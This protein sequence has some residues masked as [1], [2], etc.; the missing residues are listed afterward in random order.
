MVSQHPRGG[1]SPQSARVRFCDTAGRTR[2]YSRRRR[3]IR[4]WVLRLAVL[5]RADFPLLMHKK[6]TL[7]NTAIR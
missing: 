2:R 3:M 6:L 4:F 1:H 7:D 5:A